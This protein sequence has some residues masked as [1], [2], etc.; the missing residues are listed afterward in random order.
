MSTLAARA[1]AS[2]IS[3]QEA[4]QIM[5]SSDPYILLDV[6]TTS[7]YKEARIDGAKS[8]PVDELSRRAPAD[9]PDKHVP[10]FIYCRG[11]ARAAIAAKLLVGLGY[12]NARNM[13]GIASWP[14]GT[15]K[16]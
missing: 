11:G 13:G 2:A 5:T 6:R 9:L 8:I 12:T 7:E 3:P 4:Y 1:N 15:M 10:V 16:G 14:Y